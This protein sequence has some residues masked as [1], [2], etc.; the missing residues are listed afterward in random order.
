MFQKYLTGQLYEG[1]GVGTPAPAPVPAPAPAPAEHPVAAPWASID[2]SWKIGEGEKAVDWWETIGEEKV[3]EHVK[4]KGYKNPAELA[5]GNYNLTQLQTGSPNVV[6]LPPENAT[7]EQLNDFYTK[8][9]RPPAADKYDLKFPDGVQTDPQMVEFGKNL[10]F[11][12]GL[13]PARAQVMADKW[14]EFAGKAN[15]AAIEQ[16]Q[17]KNTAAL[18]ALET[19]WGADL[20]P[21]R[22]AGERVM[23]ALGLPET[24]MDA[25]QKAIGAAPLVELL[26]KI[27]RQSDEGGF[28]SSGKGDPNN[29]STMSPTEAQAKIAA[30]QGDAA[31]Q[32]KY[33]N[34]SHPE[35]KSS[36]E[37]M[38]ALT[39]RT[40][41]VGA[42]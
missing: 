17:V 33:T 27:G 41:V 5:M 21:N 26:A 34:K 25:I 42:T 31:F 32:E 40:F 36:V 28:K 16:E 12:L 11:E 23:K 3:R 24:T 10:A 19:Q 38:L 18:A 30:L 15:A 2:T 1:E 20:E 13:P 8:L 14:N 7:P 35:H 39:Q 29:P 4:A 22:A 6:A 37:L 9:G